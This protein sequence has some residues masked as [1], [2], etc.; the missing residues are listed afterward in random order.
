[1]P[2]R[3]LVPLDGSAIAERALPYASSI[4]RRAGGELLLVRA[5]LAPLFT[6][7]PGEDQAEETS[8]AEAELN[9]V[10]ERLRTEGLAVEPHI[11]YDDPAPTIVRAAEL[12]DADLIVMSSHG[13]SGI[14][15]WIYG[16]VTDQVL[17]SAKTPVLVIPASAVVDWANGA[18]GGRTVLVP[19]DGSDLA[20]ESLDAAVEMARLLGAGL[21]LLQV[22]PPPVYASPEGFVYVDVD[23]N[24][25]IAV[26]KAYLDG[27]ADRL[28]AS[29]LTVE[30]QAVIGDPGPLIAEE[31]RASGALLVVMATHGR[32]GIAR[33]VMGSVATGAV[34]RSPAPVLL[35][36]P[37]A[38]EAAEAAPPPTIGDSTPATHAVTVT[39]SPEEI[40]LVRLGLQELLST[41]EREEHLAAPIHRLLGRLV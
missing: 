40:D 16:S 1:M 7:E 5:A 37:A 20:E 3:I 35:L 29:D 19:L 22:A 34:Q 36:R 31:A 15:R 12:E 18:A 32:S 10:A 30:T 23:P 14:G 25:E 26:A 21:R 2:K 11:Y 28:R 4:A 27:V 41:S 33:L 17:R 24:E 39:L 6:T 8:E 13:R 38:L 9:A